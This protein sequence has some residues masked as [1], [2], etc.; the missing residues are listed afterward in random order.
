MTSNDN[1]R[2]DKV[3]MGVLMREFVFD[4]NAPQTNC[5]VPAFP[6]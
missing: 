4:R 1:Y 5:V 6:V 2:Y 3:T